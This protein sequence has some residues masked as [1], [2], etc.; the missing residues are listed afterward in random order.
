MEGN[1]ISTIEY[2]RDIRLEE[3]EYKGWS[4]RDYPY[5]KEVHFPQAI[6]DFT[7]IWVEEIDEEQ[8]GPIDISREMWSLIFKRL[9]NTLERIR[10]RTKSTTLI[11]H[12]FSRISEP[13]LSS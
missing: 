8:K 9:R 5:Q 10:K 13:I 11:N 6:A 7:L 2:V 1:V 12:A 3:W 4:L